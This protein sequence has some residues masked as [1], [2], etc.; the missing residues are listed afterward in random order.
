MNESTPPLA[1]ACVPSSA[2]TARLYDLRLQ[3]RALL[4]EFLEYL[5][6]VERRELHVTAGY[7]SVFTF[8]VGFLGYSNATAY[9][10]SHA[11][12]LLA[13]FPAI[14]AY[15]ADG[16]LGL[17]TLV[18]LR[19]VLDEAS[20]RTTLDRAAGKSEDEVKAIVAS[21]RPRSAP[22]DELRKLPPP[23]P[24]P[25]LTSTFTP[26]VL[27]LPGPAPASAPTSTPEVPAPPPPAARLEPISEELR[28]LR[29]TVGR[30]FVA[31]LHAVRDAL[32]HQIPDGNLARVLHECL[33]RVRRDLARRREAA[34]DRPARTKARPAASGGPTGRHV[35]AAVRREVFARDGGRCTFVGTDG[36]V[37][38]STAQV[39][40]HHIHPH[41]RGGPATAAN[42]TLCCRTHNAHLAERDF[43]R[44]HMAEVI[45]RA[46]SE[47]TEPRQLS[48]V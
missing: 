32:S 41:A 1:L 8:L 3:E 27:A 34:T 10:R 33:R 16:R 18:L 29:V 9:R 22:R 37:C 28:V 13:R 30:E 20:H 25:A 21:I 11:A 43:G 26:E 17:T 36:H 45:E 47:R 46:R 4:V 42:L 12:R 14:R 19:E 48:L 31:D 23:R 35:P 2:L 40:V 39:E 44:E 24:V 5:A 15:L 7:T 6:E 38:G